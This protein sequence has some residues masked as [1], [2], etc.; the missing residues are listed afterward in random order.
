M[1]VCV[2]V[3]R[4]GALAQSFMSIA[5]SLFRNRLMHQA[6]AVR[7]HGGQITDINII[8]RN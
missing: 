7:R 5:P 8:Y 4:G 3:L 1:C 2:C 6:N